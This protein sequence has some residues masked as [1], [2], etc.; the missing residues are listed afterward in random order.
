MTQHSGNTVGARNLGAF[1]PSNFW[2][3]M[4]TQQVTSKKIKYWESHKN[5]SKTEE[6]LPKFSPW[7]PCRCRMWR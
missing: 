4:P 7:H 5:I 2:F 6:Q 3:P 1:R